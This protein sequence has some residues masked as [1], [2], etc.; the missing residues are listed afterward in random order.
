MPAARAVPWI[1]SSAAGWA[2]A[3][4]P[5]TASSS[6]GQSVASARIVRQRALRS[7]SAQGG[8]LAAVRTGDRIRLGVSRRRIDLLVDED[9]IAARL[10]Q[11]ANVVPGAGR[12][13]DW[14]YRQHI[15]QAD[16][17][18]DFDFLVDERCRSQ[19]GR[20]PA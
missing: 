3:G 6:G 18:C 13:Y 8:P 11:R 19:I 4:C 9:V 5:Q 20:F 1:T 10:A 17:G 16:Q 15:L 7:A 12:G 14:L 2:S